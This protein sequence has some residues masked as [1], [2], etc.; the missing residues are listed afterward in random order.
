MILSR[1]IPEV[2]IKRK[3]NGYERFSECLQPPSEDHRCYIIVGYGSERSTVPKISS[4]I[5]LTENMKFIRSGVLAKYNDLKNTFEECQ[6]KLHH[7][8]LTFYK[9]KET[10]RDIL[11]EKRR[12]LSCP[13]RTRSWRWSTKRNACFLCGTS[14]TALFFG[15]VPRRICIVGTWRDMQAHRHQRSHQDQKLTDIHERN[16]GQVAQGHAAQTQ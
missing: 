1:K 2:V 3:I 8:Y 7:D 14:S 5:P 9:F 16:G 11:T 10:G 15:R 12:F 4:N 13:W 6:L